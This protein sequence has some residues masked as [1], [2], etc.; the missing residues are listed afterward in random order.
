MRTPRYLLLAVLLTSFA[1]LGAQ[2]GPDQPDDDPLPKR[3]GAAT[4][5]M[6]TYYQTQTVP[7]SMQ[8]VKI[9][10]GTDFEDDEL[11]LTFSM[12]GNELVTDMDVG[13]TV[14]GE[15]EA[16]VYDL[17]CRMVSPIGTKSAWKPVDLSYTK[18]HIP[19]SY[20]FDSENSSGKWKLQLRDPVKDNDGRLRFRNA[21]LRINDG[22]SSTIRGLANNATETITLTSTQMKLDVLR[23]VTAGA[24]PADFCVFGVKKMLQNNFTFTTSFSVRS[25]QIDFSILIDKSA[26]VG[27]DCLML[28]MAPSGGYAF[29][30]LEAWGS[31]PTATDLG[32]VALYQFSFAFANDI[33]L[34]GEPSLGTWTLAL[35][36]TKTDLKTM[37]LTDNTPPSM[38]LGGRTYS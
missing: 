26:N 32:S 23:E 25:F 16:K 29:G 17:Y 24:F 7:R 34:A 36:D 21:T 3:A 20:E 11:E 33:D 30:A 14:G 15:Q 38:T 37:E 22:E 19:F 10:E 13:L 18:T 5:F 8:A 28:I 9:P 6:R 31:L 27:K 1:L 4:P 12:G 35:I 2:C